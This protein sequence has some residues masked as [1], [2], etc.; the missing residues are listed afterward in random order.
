MQVTIHLL[1]S[2][3][4]YLPEAHRASGKYSEELAPGTRVADVLAGLAI[5]PDDPGTCLVNGLHA[6]LDRVLQDG[7]TLTIFPAVGGG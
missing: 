4:R 6:E 5:P 2:Y 7:D 3:R 1:V